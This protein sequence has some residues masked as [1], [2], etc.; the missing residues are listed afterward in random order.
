MADQAVVLWPMPRLKISNRVSAGQERIP[1][2][3]YAHDWIRFDPFSPARSSKLL[4]C[5]SVFHLAD[6]LSFS[7]STRSPFSCLKAFDHLAELGAKDCGDPIHRVLRV[8][9]E[10]AT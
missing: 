3:T 2:L 10:K 6:L 8:L 9:K 7:G 1:P 5:V 4:F